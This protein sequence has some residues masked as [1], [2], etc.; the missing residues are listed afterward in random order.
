MRYTVLLL[1]PEGLQVESQSLSDPA[2]V[3]LFAAEF[4]ACMAQDNLSCTVR[5]VADHGE[6]YKPGDMSGTLPGTC[7]EWQIVQ[8]EDGFDVWYDGVEYG[9]IWPTYE[10]AIASIRPTDL[11]D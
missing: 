1:D 2:S 4:L 3:A 9:E 8:N 7:R 5:M 6:P 11:G 10:A